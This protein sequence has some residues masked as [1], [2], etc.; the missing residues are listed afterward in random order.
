MLNLKFAAVGTLLALGA[1]PA[2]YAADPV[3]PG[4]IRADKKEIVQDRREFR[5]DKQEL[6]QDL[7][8]RNADRRELKQEIRE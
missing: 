8:E 2:T 7:R 6:R 4:E 1:M 3:A 5:D